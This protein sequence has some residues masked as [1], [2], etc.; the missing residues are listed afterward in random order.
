[1]EKTIL[2]IGATSAI[3]QET[4]QIYARKNWSIFC[5]GR[6]E[7]KLK[8][9]TDDLKTLGAPGVDY[10]VFDFDRI[11]SYEA[12]LKS[13]FARSPKIDVAL[14]AHGVLPDAEKAIN[15]FDTVQESGLINYSSYIAFMSL[16]ARFFETQKHGHLVVIGSVAGDRGRQSNYLYGSAKAGVAAFC[17]GLRGRLRPAGVF[18]T[19]IKPGMVDTPMTAHLKKGPL[20][21]SSASVA[22]GLVKAIEGKKAVAYL[23]GFWFFIMTIIKLLPRAIFDRLKF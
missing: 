23:P 12:Q 1:M 4:A 18:V 20:F 22:K 15:D 9:I 5:V 6:N 19:L 16:L 17:E 14:I 10:A 21:A 13:I 11:D 2:I 7:A 8:T 3:A